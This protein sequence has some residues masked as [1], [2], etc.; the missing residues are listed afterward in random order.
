MNTL[1]DKIKHVGI[2][3]LSRGGLF[4]KT[5]IDLSFGEKIKQIR[6]VKGVRQRH[7][8]SE[9]SLT[10]ARLSQLELGEDAG[11]GEIGSDTL[12]QLKKLLGVEELPLTETEREG[13][14]LDLAEW[15]DL[16]AVRK[17]E[18]AKE[19][20]EVLSVITFAPFDEELNTLFNL[21]NCRLELGLGNRSIAEGILDTVADKY[22]RSLTP[23]LLYYYYLS[24]GALSAFRKQY[25]DALVF[26]TKAFELKSYV[27]QDIG[28]YY[29][30]AIR[31]YNVGCLSRSIMFL[32]KALKLCA[33]EQGNIWERP[34]KYMLVRNHIGLR[35]LSSAKKLLG[36]LRKEAKETG[37]KQFLCD[38]FAFYGYMCR[39]GEDYSTCHRYLNEAMKYVDDE[40]SEYYLEILYQKARCY[41]AEGGFT[42][43]QELLKDCKRMS[44]GNKHYTIAFESLRHLTTL[45]HEGGSTEYLETVALPHLLNEVPKYATALD[46]CEFL[47]KHYGQK[48]IG[49]I[50]KALETEKMITHILR[51][52]LQKGESK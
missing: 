27:K 38:V 1:T 42:V 19:M 29:S 30:I 8:A 24:K 50:K 2:L 31:S 7:L 5:G 33:K 45:K 26:T 36:K 11:F 40:A 20:R 25:E 34:I 52:M 4:I 18:E 23:E 15:N 41:I 32:K 43:C 21:I 10:P 51:R 9:L 14:K 47:E 16:I 6:Q 44:K 48:H 28:L 17:L 22:M 49:T 13:F 46:Y 12:I 3:L 39:V 37:D 35:D